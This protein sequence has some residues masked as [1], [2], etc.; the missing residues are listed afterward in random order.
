LR[1]VTL[2][3]DAV[4]FAAEMRRLRK[5]T[6]AHEKPDSSDTRR[7]YE[8]LFAVGAYRQRLA[9]LVEPLLTA[10]AEAP[11]EVKVAARR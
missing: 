3:E 5:A 8:N 11:V 1:N 4:A 6:D 7:L 10:G 2:A 9:D